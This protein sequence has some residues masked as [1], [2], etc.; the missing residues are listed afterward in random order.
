MGTFIR[1]PNELQRGSGILTKY[2]IVS[3]KRGGGMT[4]KYLT[5]SS[6]VEFFMLAGDDGEE[7]VEYRCGCS[8]RP[9]P[10]S[11]GS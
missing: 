7:S 6:I 11:R 10:I 1:V 8:K 4:D 5:Q 9:L 2:R 3:Q